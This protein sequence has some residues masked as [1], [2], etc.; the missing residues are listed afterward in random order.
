V[1]YPADGAKVQ[2]L[3]KELL[4]RALTRVDAAE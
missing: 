2:E 1:G 4:N 3:A